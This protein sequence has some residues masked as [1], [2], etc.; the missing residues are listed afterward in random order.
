MKKL[1]ILLALSALACG[2]SAQLPQVSPTDTQISPTMSTDVKMVVIADTLNV[3]TEAGEKSPLVGALSR[4]D[5]VT[6]TERKAFDGGEWCKHESG[7]SN[8]RWLR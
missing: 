2:A 8:C 5:I 3:R 6:V 7:W 4:G 1:L